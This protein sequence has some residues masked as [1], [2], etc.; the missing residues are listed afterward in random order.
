VI[1]IE[2]ITRF[3]I[4]ATGVLG[5]YREN[6][7]IFNQADGSTIGDRVAWLKA[8][9]QQRNWD[10]VNQIIALRCLPYNIQAPRR[11]GEVWK[12]KF[13]LDSP[14]ALSDQPGD[15]EFLRRDAQGVPM[16]LG[17]DETTGLDATIQTQGVE[18]NT[19]FRILG[20]K[21]EIGD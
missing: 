8:R 6:R 4:T 17:L 3:D 14:A 10:T 19:S 2:C 18:V 21:Y 9:N 15:L 13:D 1:T 20:D 11:Q 7:E 5:Q 16:I 12:F